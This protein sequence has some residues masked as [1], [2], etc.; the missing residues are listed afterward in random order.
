MKTIKQAA[1]DFSDTDTYTRDIV[2]FKAAVEFAQRWIP[3]DEDLPQN[4]MEI[5]AKND[6]WKETFTFYTHGLRDE[7]YLRKFTHWRPIELK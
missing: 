5:T 2:V 3:V 7:E 1:Y 6:Y 4:E